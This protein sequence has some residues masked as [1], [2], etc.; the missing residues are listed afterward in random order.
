M[1]VQ[2]SVFHFHSFQTLSIPNTRRSHSHTVTPGRH[3]KQSTSTE[4]G[5]QE[6]DSLASH[7]SS[8]LAHFTKRTG[9]VD[10]CCRRRRAGYSPPR[11]SFC[12]KQCRQCALRRQCAVRHRAWASLT[13][14]SRKARLP[15]PPKKPNIVPCRRC[16][17]GGAIRR[18]WRR[19]R[20]RSRDGARKS[21]QKMRSSRSFKRRVITLH[22]RS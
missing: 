14:Y 3:T 11:G 19:T 16:S 2:K 8:L 13:T 4:R 21:P 22:G 18:R 20:R 17:T 12:S 15:R 5:T 9:T 1:C 7:L 10:A 6:E